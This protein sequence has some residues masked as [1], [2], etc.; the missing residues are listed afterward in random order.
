VRWLLL[1]CWSLLWTLLKQVAAAARPAA[2]WF[3]CAAMFRTTTITAATP[4][5]LPLAATPATPAMVAAAAMAASVLQ[6]LRLLH[7]PTCLLL[8]L[9]PKSQLPSCL[10]PPV[11]NSASSTLS[12][13]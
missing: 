2:A 1:L 8:R 3:A 12:D 10:Y 7:L 6:L 9:L 4:A 11:G 5:Q 13:L